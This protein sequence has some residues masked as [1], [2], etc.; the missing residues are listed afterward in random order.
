MLLAGTI[1]G[2]PRLR[3]TYLWMTKAEWKLHNYPIS[4]TAEPYARALAGKNPMDIITNDGEVK[5]YLHRLEGE[6]ELEAL[7]KAMKGRGAGRLSES[8]GMALLPAADAKEVQ[9]FDNA[10]PHMAPHLMDW[11]I[12][13]VEKGNLSF[14]PDARSG[15]YQY[16]QYALQALLVLSGSAEERVIK[17][18]KKYREHLRETFRVGITRA[19]ETHSKAVSY[20][21]G[22]SASTE[23][24]PVLVVSPCLLVEPLPT[25][26][27]RL[28]RCYRYLTDT[29]E[30][31]FGREYL[32]G[33]HIL[34]EDDS[35]SA[36][37][38]LKD[39]QEV[40]NLTYG[41]YAVACD[42][43]GIEAKV[44]EKDGV[45]LE[46]CRETAKFWLKDY[47]ND[48][49]LA[50]D[51]R[52]ATPVF[53]PTPANPWMWYWGT[54]G[55]RMLRIRVKYVKPPTVTI[56]GRKM[57]A[58][59]VHLGSREYLIA[60]DRFITF[61]RPFELGPLSR[62]RYREVLDKAGSLSEA[63]KMLEEAK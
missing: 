45:D 23:A 27:L 22:C 50:K 29:A 34:R 43:L 5:D 61:R 44:A 53:R 3:D 58:G 41:L 36:T 1:W 49:R 48:W 16:Q 19:R 31:L 17:F 20:S 25:F 38:A 42:E 13:E 6:P 30:D 12:S 15:W 33:A 62:T 11:L 47:W 54:S 59:A 52:V 9:L 18:S 46:V 4:L 24:E 37:S 7:K 14:R 60:A 21:I 40:T 32:G 56:D 2:E 35:P 10:P 8:A 63:H 26:Y 55:I 28:A 39:L 51:P 57:P